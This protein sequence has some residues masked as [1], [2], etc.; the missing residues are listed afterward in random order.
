MRVMTFCAFSRF[1]GG[2]DKWVFKLFFEGLMAFE[3]EF[4]LGA[5]L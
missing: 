1:Y 4:P 5:R 3:T 2:M